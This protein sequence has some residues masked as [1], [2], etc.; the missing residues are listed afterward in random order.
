MTG[1]KEMNTSLEKHGFKMSVSH[2][3]TLSKLR[4]VRAAQRG[5]KGNLQ[6]QVQGQKTFG[7]KPMPR[8]RE[9]KSHWK[10][11]IK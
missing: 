9:G 3:N 2:P 10:R 11:P 6:D 7:S 1:G 8:L 5:H 4:G